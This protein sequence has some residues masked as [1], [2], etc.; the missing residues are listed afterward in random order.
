M[1]LRAAAPPVGTVEVE[2]HRDVA[3]VKLIGEHDMTTV[4]AVQDVL[5]DLINADMPVVVSLAEATFID[6]TTIGVLCRSEHELIAR[7]GRR[8]VIHVDA[9]IP[10]YKTLAISGA[11]DILIC[12]GNLTEAIL[13]ARQPTHSWAH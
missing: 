8:Y 5:V 1:A 3:V 2:R 12:H 6:S 13:A 9:S 4:A 10:V 7:H 11:R